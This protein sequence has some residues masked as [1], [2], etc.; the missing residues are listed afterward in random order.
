VRR[1]RVWPGLGVVTAVTIMILMVV[2]AGAQQPT[3]SITWADLPAALRPL[4][5]AR[6]LT[7]AGFPAFVT[8]TREATA[9]RVREGQLDHVIFYALQSTHFT[10]LPPIEPAISAKAF[11]DALDAD[12][13]AR[14]RADPLSV[15]VTRVPQPVAQ[16]IGA[17]LAA[18][19]EQE[20]RTGAQAAVVA[21][22]DT[23]VRLFGKVVRDAFPARARSEQRTGLLQAYLRAMRFLYEQ[24]ELNW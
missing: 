18:F 15:P 14:F 9:T 10:A 23:R 1:T 11:M 21:A 7:S 12:T 24:K 2:A 5:E 19:D 4:L 8:Q 20:R 3:A 16:R 17:L 22:E 13:R 6:G